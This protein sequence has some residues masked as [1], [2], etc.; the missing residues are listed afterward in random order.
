VIRKV[1]ENAGGD[2]TGVKA[3]GIVLVLDELNLY[4]SGAFLQIKTLLAAGHGIA[5]KYGGVVTVLVSQRGVDLPLGARALLTRC[6]SMKQQHP[7]DVARLR[8]EFG[9][10]FAHDAK[11]W[12]GHDEPAFWE[13]EKFYRK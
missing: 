9:A 1:R 3:Q 10:D 8:E 6:Y 2:E 5:E 7:A 4:S 13:Q 11:H 12:E